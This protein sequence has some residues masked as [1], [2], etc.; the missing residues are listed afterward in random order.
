MGPGRSA[1][2]HHL[3]LG[4]LRESAPSPATPPFFASADGRGRL[5]QGLGGDFSARGARLESFGAGV[6]LRSWPLESKWRMR[7]RPFPGGG[8]TS[9]SYE[10]KATKWP[11]SVAFECR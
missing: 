10:A 5:G 2:L 4:Q 9:T 7:P 6:R 11:R 3:A 1:P 8:V